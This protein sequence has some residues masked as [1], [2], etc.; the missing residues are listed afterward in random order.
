M[1]VHNEFIANFH[2]TTRYVCICLFVSLYAYLFVGFCLFVCLVVC[3]F[4][5]ILI[6]L[7]V[8]VSVFSMCTLSLFDC[9]ASFFVVG[10]FCA[11]VF[12]VVFI[13]LFALF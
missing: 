8:C 10:L 5:H 13:C 11:Y 1:Y 12:V 6:C 7:L 2:D 4:L 9:I 3:V